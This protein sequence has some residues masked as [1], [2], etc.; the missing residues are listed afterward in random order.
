MRKTLLLVITSLLLTVAGICE[1]KISRI[2]KCEDGLYLVYFDTTAFKKTES[3]AAIIVLKKYIIL[4]ELP[5]VYDNADRTDHVREGRE[6]IHELKE[7]FPNKPLRYI[8]S[9]HWHPH[10]I[11]AVL[12][13]LENGTTIVTTHANLKRINEV[14]DST[15]QNKYRDQFVFVDQDSLILGDPGN[16]V[17][18]YHARQSDYTSLPVTDFLFTYS[19][20]YKLIQS[21]CM[22]RRYKSSH[23]MDRELVSGRSEN[24]YEFI[25][26]KNLGVEKILCTETDQDASTGYIPFDTLKN[27]INTG[28]KA[29]ELNTMILKTCNDPS[30]TTDSAIAW[31]I[32]NNIPGSS[33]NSLVY[34]CLRL[35][36]LYSALQLARYNALIRPSDPNSWDTY[37]EVFYFKNKPDI[38]RYF[39]KQ[40]KKI[41]KDF[42][43]GGEKVWQ[44]DKEVISAGWNRK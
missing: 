26:A 32:T 36:N 43:E 8:V 23:V 35:G 4:L 33:V 3:K 30:V 29:S 17:I 34:E 25:T 38:A 1:G 5:L 7:Q 16:T 27:L 21:S 9:S 18:I 39:E 13:M 11:S 40:S 14:I 2:K 41:D 44:K 10:S 37:G 22:Y 19:S 15:N 42:S 12:P 31:L 6:F 28:I 24:L 20:R